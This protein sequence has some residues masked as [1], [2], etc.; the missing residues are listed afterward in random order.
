[1][2]VF[3]GFLTP[4]L[5]KV[6]LQATGHRKKACA[7]W[8]SHIRTH[9]SFPPSHWLLI[10]SCISG[11]EGKGSQGRKIVPTGIETT[12]I[13]PHSHC[14]GHQTSSTVVTL[15]GRLHQKLKSKSTLSCEIV[16]IHS[17]F[18]HGF[19]KKAKSKF[20]LNRR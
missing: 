9:K 17:L 14:R 7:S 3:P 20:N 11:R 15:K 16:Q 6:T 5:T 8:F 13:R 2:L 19:I 12:A 18:R 10:V 1:M 4:E